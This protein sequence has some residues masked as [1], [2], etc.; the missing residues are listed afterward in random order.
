MVV[1]LSD[2]WEL[3]SWIKFLVFVASLVALNIPLPV[4]NI[5]IGTFII[6]PIIEF[7]FRVLGLNF[8]YEQFVIIVFLSPIVLFIFKFGH[9]SRNRTIIV[10][11]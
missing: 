2:F 3:P 7:P 4:L 11:R 5:S 1:G 9:S 6:K 8:S 10:R